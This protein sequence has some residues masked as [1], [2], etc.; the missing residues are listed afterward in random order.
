MFKKQIYHIRGRKFSFHWLL[1]KNTVTG[2]MLSILIKFDHLGIGH[3]T[4]QVLSLPLKYQNCTYG[5][6]F[7]NSGGEMPIVFQLDTLT[8][9]SIQSEPNQSNHMPTEI[10]YQKQFSIHGNINYISIPN[11][12]YK[13]VKSSLQLSK[14]KSSYLNLV[15][16]I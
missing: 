13:K 16:L 12:V 1:I 4:R 5:S 10:S 14:T 8:R 6:Y 2:N 9:S 15:T 7:T 11:K 3:K